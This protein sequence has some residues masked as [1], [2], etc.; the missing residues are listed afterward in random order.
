MVFPYHRAVVGEER[1]Q[2]QMVAEELIIG[3]E[4]K[5]EL[6]I[7]RMELAENRSVE[8]LIQAYHCRDIVFGRGC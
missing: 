4:G 1:K 7:N 5:M 2:R 8:I 6:T 3:T